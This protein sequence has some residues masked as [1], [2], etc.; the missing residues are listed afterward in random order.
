MLCKDCHGT[1]HCPHCLGTGLQSHLTWREGLAGAG[2]G[3][4]CYS[5]SPPGSGLC[6]NCEGR[7][8]LEDVPEKS[9]DRPAAKVPV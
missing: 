7:G 1:G 5:C 9:E 4:R 8:I 6:S 3:V 2:Q